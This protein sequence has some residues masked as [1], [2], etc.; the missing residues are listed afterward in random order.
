MSVANLTTHCSCIRGRRL[1]K[2][3]CHVDVFSWRVTTLG[4]FDSARLEDVLDALAGSTLAAQNSSGVCSHPLTCQQM[5]ALERSWGVSASDYVT[6]LHAQCGVMAKV[7]D[8]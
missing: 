4:A 3:G 1:R 8:H 2:R 6:M 7:S 5:R